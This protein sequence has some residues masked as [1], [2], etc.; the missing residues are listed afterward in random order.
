M[1]ITSLFLLQA[2]DCCGRLT[3]YDDPT[4]GTASGSFSEE[5]S[6]D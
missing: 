5:E 6:K 1:I 3:N 4:Y 2:I